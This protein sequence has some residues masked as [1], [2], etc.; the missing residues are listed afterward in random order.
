MKA[1]FI[2]RNTDIALLVPKHGHYPLLCLEAITEFHIAIHLSFQ[3]PDHFMLMSYT[4][5]EL[6]AARFVR[7]LNDN[8]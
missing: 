8:A 3:Q 4:I 6:T 2:I 7:Y 1:K 5:T